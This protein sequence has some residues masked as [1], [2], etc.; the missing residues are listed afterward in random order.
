M[1]N[2][3]QCK[4][5]ENCCKTNTALELSET[6][7]PLILMRNLGGDELYSCVQMRTLRAHGY[8]VVGS[9]LPHGGRRPSLEV[10]SHPQNHST[11]WNI[12]FQP[13]LGKHFLFW[14]DVWVHT[15]EHIKNSVLLVPVFFTET[16]FWVVFSLGA[17]I[18][19]MVHY[20]N[21]LWGKFLPGEVL[22]WQTWLW[23]KLVQG[24]KKKKLIQGIHHCHRQ[25]PGAVGVNAG[26]VR[27][28]GRKE[29]GFPTT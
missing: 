22:S 5:E 1:Q 6:S 9:G 18:W 21:R 15:F 3:N 24:K 20:K 29:P 19:W 7:S 4:D 8:S 26:M 28:T 11:F 25:E 10:P 12:F 14:C 13:F 27:P 2:S 23:M 16:V 17:F